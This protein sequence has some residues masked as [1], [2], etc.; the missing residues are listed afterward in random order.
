MFAIGQLMKYGLLFLA[1]AVLCGAGALAYQVGEKS[2]RLT[3]RW[4][5]PCVYVEGR[6]LEYCLS[7]TPAPVEGFVSVRQ[8]DDEEYV[9]AKALLFFKSKARRVPGQSCILEY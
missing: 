2:T 6:A 1:A 3:A 7:M 8:D 5:C 4:V 9:E